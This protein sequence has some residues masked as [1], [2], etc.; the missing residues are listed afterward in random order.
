M[1]ALLAI[2]AHAQPFFPHFPS[3]DVTPLDGAWAF[4]FD[5]SFGDAL[6]PFE[7]SQIATPE[8]VSVP[9]AF[10][11]AQ[12]GVLGRRGTAFYR[13]DLTV[14]TGRRGLLHFAACSF[15][16]RVWLDGTELGA[17]FGG[18]YTPFWLDVPP[19]PTRSKRELFVL[20]DNRFNKT[21][22]P[23]HTGG[24]FYEYGGIT[25][26]V[27]LHVLPPADG[28][29]IDFLGVLPLNTSHVNVTIQL[30]GG[31]VGRVERVELAFDSAAAP[32]ATI[33][34]LGAGG[35]SATAAHVP[36]PAARP[37]HPASPFL[38]TLRATVSGSGDSAIARF[39]LRTVGVTADGRFALN[40]AALKLKGVN[41]HTMSAASGSALTLAEV[42]RDVKL[43][44]QLGVNYVRGAHYPQ[45]QRFLDRCDE[46]GILVWEETLGPNV[47]TADTLSKYFMDAQL[48]QVRSMVRASFSHPSIVFHGFFNEGPSNDPAACAGYNA[49][50][51]AIRALVP[52]SHRMV[53]W[54]SAEKKKDKC[55]AAA[56][57]LAFNEYPGWYTESYD[58]VNATWA[59]FSAWARSNYPNKP[60][61]I[62]ETGAGGIYEWRDNSSVQVR[63][64]GYSVGKGALSAG[65]DLDKRNC[66]LVEAEAHCNASASCKGFTFRG[67]G[68]QPSGTLLVYFKARA[69]VNS[70]DE[71]VSWVK[72]APLPPKWSQQFQADLVEKDVRAALSIPHVSGI[73][74]WQFMD[75]KADDGAT[76]SCGS[77]VYA[78]PYNASTPMDCAIISA[79]CWRPGGENHKGLVD[80]W[81]RPKR[82]FASVQKLFMHDTH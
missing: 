58:T 14:P 26:S 72:G 8:S 29:Y 74:L 6:R 53:T 44:V 33:R 62:S 67:D 48:L 47:N 38:H 63:V 4:G 73:S 42:E 69:N 17:H 82:V 7:P 37:W 15:F 35:H 70:D 81:R 10:D 39:G 80:L 25:R 18:G 76:K 46:E 32:Q 22:A 45:D 68:L 75:I 54:A 55:F 34:A 66:T 30:R 13:R 28:A 5:P 57:V 78:K 12:P 64:G 19:E 52:P 3:R 79:H 71:W 11:V 20:V 61:L 49:S 60:F 77:C 16:C 43:L 65:S 50:A 27:M 1:L 41:R 9:S 21:T 40:G 56:D 36:V 31:A 24:D 2:A 23:V 59:N 51:A